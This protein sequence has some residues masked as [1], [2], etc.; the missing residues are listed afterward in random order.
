M[1]QGKSVKNPPLGGRGRG[2][3]TTA[4]ILLPTMQLVWVEGREKGNE[5]EPGKKCV[6]D[7]FIF[8]S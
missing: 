4:P 1:E 6:R 8:F 2:S 5:V 7:F 3:M